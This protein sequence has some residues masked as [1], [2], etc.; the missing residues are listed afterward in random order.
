MKDSWH[1]W[2]R[3]V[4]AAPALSTTVGVLVVLNTGLLILTAVLV[5]RA[6]DV[7]A[8][9]GGGQALVPPLV[10]LMATLVGTALTVALLPPA[11]LRLER[12]IVL[13]QVDDVVHRIALTESAGAGG[14][15]TPAPGAVAERVVSMPHREALGSV[16]DLLRTRCRGWAGAVVLSLVAP[17][18]AVV[19]AASIMAYGR[20]FTKFLDDVLAGLA[21]QGPLAT[22][23]ARYV[24]SLH[25]DHGIAGELRTFRA[26]PWLLRS[27]VR[28]SDAGRAEAFRERQR[29]VKS[30]AGH[31]LLCAVV[32]LGCLTWLITRAWSGHLGVMELALGIQGALLMLDLGPAGDV[33]VRFRQAAQVERDLANSGGAP[34]ARSAPATGEATAPDIAV[35]CRSIRH[36][37]PGAERAALDV[38]ELTIRKGERVAVVGRNGAG[39]STLFG[40]IAGFL[41]A[42]EGSVDVDRA[43]VS[44][45]IQRAVRYPATLRE[46]VSLGHCVVDVDR[47]FATIGQVADGL[48][49][50][51][52]DEFLGGP[53]VQ[54]SNLSDGQWQRIGLARAFGHATSGVL[55]L[56]E[57]SAALDPAAEAEFF[58]TALDEAHGCTVLLSTHHL[59]NTR[60]VDRIIVLDSGR[61]VQEGTHADLLRRG[62]LYA[63]MFATQAR[64]YGVRS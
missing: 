26:L 38:P 19:L 36:V 41:E 39:K 34:P 29:H 6:V 7:A 8:S 46:N 60:F 44:I 58:R 3:A 45:A 42:T 32:L 17:V 2:R 28:L 52:A 12:A 5:S 4:T 63:D 18:M 16:A 35:T 22:R 54:G 40:I 59:A 10:A 1:V 64:S 25:F 33:A 24:R 37:Y 14:G 53:A 56:D 27:F 61:I 50:E 9:G 55:L 20:A 11:C 13:H 23:R 62:G 47:A 51:R 49:L 57:P 30:L 15:G 31:S 48:A 21:S 43:G